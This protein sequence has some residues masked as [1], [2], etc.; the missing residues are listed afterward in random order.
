MWDV[1]CEMWD[2][3]MEL[4]DSDVEV[5]MSLSAQ[6]VELR[7]EGSRPVNVSGWFLELEGVREITWVIP[8]TDADIT[9]GDHAFIAAKTTGC[10]PEPDWVIP[11]M[12]FSFGVE[13]LNI[14]AKKKRAD[15]VQLRKAQLADIIGPDD[16]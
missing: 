7:N 16:R 14:R 5:V 4:P 2:R 12:A 10:F 8:Q 3:E 11:A 6:E 15:H 9:P 1:E 13:I